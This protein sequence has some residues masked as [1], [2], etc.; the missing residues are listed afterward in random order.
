LCFSDFSFLFIIKIVLND[1][2]KTLSYR[3]GTVNDFH[4]GFKPV[5]SYSIQT[6]YGVYCY[7]S[8][9]SV[10]RTVLSR[11]CRTRRYFK[12][13]VSIRFFTTE[14]F[15]T[16]NEDERLSVLISPLALQ[17]WSAVGCNDTRPELAG[18][19]VYQLNTPA[20]VVVSVQNQCDN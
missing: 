16:D 12:R 3:N 4:W 1:L 11:I 17:V 13:F 2:S 6:E 19:C 7:E 9:S 20:R 5:L 10:K 14:C 18:R 8:T 15:N